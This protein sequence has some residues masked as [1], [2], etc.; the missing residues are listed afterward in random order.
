MRT[1]SLCLFKNPLKSHEIPA[2]YF[3]IT[4]LFYKTNTQSHGKTYYFRRKQKHFHR[5]IIENKKSHPLKWLEM[6]GF[7]NQITFHSILKPKPNS[8]KNH[9]QKPCDTPLS[10]E[11]WIERF[12]QKR[13]IV[14]MRKGPFDWPVIIHFTL[15][16]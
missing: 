6:G 10:L 16:N 13:N 8:L 15:N 9:H 12:N 3:L 14:S 2:V 7:T 5:H 4:I 1:P 11:I